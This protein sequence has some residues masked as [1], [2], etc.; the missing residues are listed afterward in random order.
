[1]PPDKFVK[2]KDQTG[3]KRLMNLATAIVFVPLFILVCIALVVD[4]RSG[5]SLQWWQNVLLVIFGPTVP[6]LLVYGT[7]KTIYWLI[8]GFRQG[9]K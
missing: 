1:M 5:H 3:F 6:A 8:D 2:L 4:F 9:T 7:F